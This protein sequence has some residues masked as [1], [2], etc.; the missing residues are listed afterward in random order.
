MKKDRIS[1]KIFCFVLSVLMAFGILPIFQKPTANAAGYYTSVW[2]ENVTPTDATIHAKINGTKINTLGFYIGTTQNNL[3]KKITEK[4]STT[5]ITTIWYNMNK[6][7]GTLK[8]EQTYYYQFFIVVGGKEQK[9]EIKSFKTTSFYQKIWV[10][11]ITETDAT[12]HA[13]LS[14]PKISTL[15][16]YIGVSS[17]NLDKKITEN[18]STISVYD[19]WYNMNKWYGK[20]KDGQV[21]YYQFFFVLNGK[22]YKSQVQSF[23]TNSKQTYTVKYDGNGG[24][25]IPVTQTKTKGTPL[26]LSDVIPS[27]PNFSFLGWSLDPNATKPDFSPN[28]SYTADANVT[29]YAVWTMTNRLVSLKWEETYSFENSS[30]VFKNK[31]YYISDSDYRKL[32]SYVKNYYGDFSSKPIINSLQEAKNNN[33]KGSCYGMA[34]TTILDKLGKIAFNENFDN[35]ASMSEVSPPYKNAHVESAINYYHL[36]QKL[37]FCRKGKIY[38]QK[39]ANWSAGL[40]GLVNAVKSGQ[41]TLFMYWFNRGKKELGH[42]I[43]VFGYTENADG[44][45]TLLSYDNRYPNTNTLIAIDKDFKTC[46]VNGNEKATGVEYYTNF[47]D[48]DAID[49]DGPNNDMSLNLSGMYAEMNDTILVLPMNGTITVENATNQ[50]LII[51]NG[52]IDGDL[53]VYDQWI[54]LEGNDAEEQIPFISLAVPNSDYYTIESDLSNLSV[55][56]TS[57]KSFASVETSACDSIV[58]SESEGV[59]ILG[60]QYT[61]TA[62]LTYPNDT[63]DMITLSGTAEGDV[64]LNY[65]ATDIQ[66]TGGGG[67]N[68]VSVFS[69]LTTVSEVSFETDYDSFILTSLET[70]DSNRF[71]VL[72]APEGDDVYTFSVLDNEFLQEGQKHTQHVW[73]EGVITENGTVYTCTICGDIFTSQDLHPVV[74]LGDVDNNKLLTSADARL[75]LRCAVQLETYSPGSI[76]FV[77]CDV[78]KDNKV[79][80]SDARKILRAAVALE[81]PAEW[82]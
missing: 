62:Y 58:L 76:E 10:D 26:T 63:F 55:S 51:R 23:V 39:K 14:G 18:I 69:D 81:D 36:A 71:A 33:W 82:E 7:F 80:A 74:M 53:S 77:A 60:D 65:R 12:I 15:G 4:I 13:K 20:L 5:K 73:D 78:D 43:V 49:I 8:P 28:G 6:W 42:A 56:M 34:V 61:Y 32:V 75:A 3:N 37:P 64:S 16:F 25:G 59:Y 11:G 57:S 44:S 67:A 19:A 70:E 48:F 79:T 40:K 9:S 24:E 54:V 38:S 30:S 52:E 31:K 22:E 41:L 46:L 72:A 17:N 66:V 29:L 47:N 27:R 68:E 35:A 21:Y 1:S 45:Y 50:K 2:V